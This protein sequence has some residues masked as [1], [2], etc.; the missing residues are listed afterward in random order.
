M[1]SPRK[2]Q[3]RLDWAS[4]RDAETH[5]TCVNELVTSLPVGEDKPSWEQFQQATS[6]AASKVLPEKSHAAK[7]PWIS[8]TT[9]ELV[10]QKR[11]AR[12]QGDWSAEKSLRKQVQKQARRDK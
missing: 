6:N 8:T 12:D 5:R 4:L 9:L 11:L 2:Q 10:Q 3:Q 1:H 7:K